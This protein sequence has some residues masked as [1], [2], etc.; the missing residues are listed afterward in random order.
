M[1]RIPCFKAY[2]IRGH[3][4]VDVTESLARRLGLA[5]G[6]VLKAQRIVVGRDARAA[7]PRLLDALAEGMVAAGIEVLDLGLCGTEEVYFATAHFKA[8]AGVMVTASH[9]PIEYNGFKL[10][11]RNAAP[12]PDM[13]FRAIEA[14][15]S[16]P[17]PKTVGYGWRRAVRCREAYVARILSAIDPSAFGP[18]HLLANAGNGA[19]GPSFDA[20]IDALVSAG[21]PITV[22]RL[23]HD[24]DPAFPNGI[25]NP[26]LPEHQ[27]VTAEAVLASGADLG[28]AWDGDFDRCFLFDAAGQFV[29]GE[30]V[31]GLLAKTMLAKAAGACIVHDPRVMWNTQAMVQ[32][33]GGKAVLGKTGHALIK[34]RMREVNAIYG[35]EMSGHHYFRDFMYCDSGMM[36]WVL[37]LGLMSQTGLGLA[38]IVDEMRARYPSSGEISFRVKDTD[39]AMQAVLTAFGRGDAQVDWFD[40]LSVSTSGWRFN[41]RL[42]NT[43]PLLRL[44]VEALANEQCVAELANKISSVLR[45]FEPSAGHL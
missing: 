38:E 16:R 27:L 44:N 39:A 12:L 11:G 22:T 10:V 37:I 32:S 6:K 9:N 14:A 4:D 42:S 43:E 26:L 7:S 45:A 3:V 20:I 5:V 2:D 36:P 1:T 8:C 33:A 18:L 40:G 31:V 17:W 28:I 15:T 35:G 41:L 19:A 29:P 21:A 34:A 30:Y 23:Y 24:P 25:P 13:I